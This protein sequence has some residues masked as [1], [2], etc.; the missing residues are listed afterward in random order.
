[1]VPVVSLPSLPLPLS[2]DRKV[3]L[4]ISPQNLAQAKQRAESGVDL[5]ALRF[6][7]DRTCPAE[8][9][10]TLRQE[11]GDKIETIEIDSSKDNPYQ[12]P[13]NAHAVLTRHFVERDGHPTKEALERV[14]SFLKAKLV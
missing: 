13:Q 12:I 4:G 2:S 11:F 9:F 14:L 7:E 1:M 5:L 10:A 3:A 6:S 8:R